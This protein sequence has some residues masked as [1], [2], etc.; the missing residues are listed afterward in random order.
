MLP[1]QDQVSYMEVLTYIPRVSGRD[2]ERE[3]ERDEKMKAI[4]IICVFQILSEGK[5]ELAVAV[6]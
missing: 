4:S 5:A 6:G 2:S 1:L 3:R